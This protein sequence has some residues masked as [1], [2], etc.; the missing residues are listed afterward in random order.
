MTEKRE[1][2]TD[3]ELYDES[4][5]RNTKSEAFDLFK[6]IIDHINLLGFVTVMDVVTDVSKFPKPKNWQYAVT[7]GWT[8]ANVEHFTMRE[9]DDGRWGVFLGSPHVLLN[10]DA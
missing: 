4:L 10:D 3:G 1:F 2:K 7:H 6:K 5:R 9:L 8:R